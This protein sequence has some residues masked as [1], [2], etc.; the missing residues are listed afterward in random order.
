MK[1]PTAIEHRHYQ[2]IVGGRV[3]AVAWDVESFDFP[4]PVLMITMPSGRVMECAVLCDP[5]GNGPG[6]LDIFTQGHAA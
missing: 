1:G 4:T 2:Q 5:E 3:K 6:F